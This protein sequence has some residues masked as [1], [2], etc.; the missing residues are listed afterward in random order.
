MQSEKLIQT[1]LEQTRQIINQAEKLKSFDLQ[2]LTW[3][4]SE[5]SW[6]ILECLKHLNLYGNFYLPQIENKIKNSKTKT[7]LEFK[8]GMLGN[9]FAKSILPKEKLNKMKTFKDKNP[10]NSKLDKT[11]ID[12]FINQQ[13]KLL[14]LLNQ[15]RNVSLNKVKIQTSISSIIK[16]KLGDT[17]QFF[18]NHII[19]HLK[20]I[21][22]IQT[23]MKNA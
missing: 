2:T 20:Q 16:L 19:R 9:Y 21:D 8:S 11:V 15:S 6:S 3:K 5:T 13:I 22:R 10:L 17:F 23:A 18:I 1:L 14:D 7:D 4:E 12:E